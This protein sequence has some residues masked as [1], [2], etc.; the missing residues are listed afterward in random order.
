MSLKTMDYVIKEN[1]LDNVDKRST[2]L[3]FSKDLAE[4]FT[5]KNKYNE[6][7]LKAHPTKKIVTTI[8]NSHDSSKFITNYPVRF[9]EGCGKYII[10][11]IDDETY[12]VMYS[13]TI[14]IEENIY[15]YA[16]IQE[17]RKE[18][19]KY[20]YSIAKYSMQESINSIRRTGSINQL[21]LE[22]KIISNEIY[23][24]KQDILNE[25]IHKLEE[26][27]KLVRSKVSD[28]NLELN[29]LNK[30]LQNYINS[31]LKRLNRLNI[32][33]IAILWEA[34]KFLIDHAS[35]NSLLNFHRLDR[36][37]H[38]DKNM[39]NGDLVYVHVD[40]DES[41]TNKDYIAM[42]HKNT[43][44]SDEIEI[45]NDNNDIIKV[46]ISSISP[47]EGIHYQLKK[48]ELDIDLY[49]IPQNLYYN[50]LSKIGI[51]KEQ[52]DTSLIEI[53]NN[54][55]DN[56]KTLQ[57]N[58]INYG[59]VEKPIKKSKINIKRALELKSKSIQAPNTF[60]E[61]TNLYTTG[62]NNDIFM[63]YSKSS[64]KPLPGAGTQESIKSDINYDS[65]GIID[66]WR[67]KLSNFWTTTNAIKIAD[68]EFASVEHFFHFMKFWEINTLS[69]AKR[70]QYNS[71]ALNFTINCEDPLCWGRSNAN[72]AK[73]KGGIKSGLNHRDEWFQPIE[74]IF[75]NQDHD[76]YGNILLRD[77]ILAVGMYHKFMQNMDLKEM[78]LSTKE[79][80]LI[81]P[82]GGSPRSGIYLK[83]Y[84]LMFVR[85]LIK[86]K[87]KIN[88]SFLDETLKLSLK[89]PKIPSKPPSD[90]PSDSPSKPPPPSKP[91]SGSP[92]KLPPKSPKSPK[93]LKSP[94]K[95]KS[96]LSLLKDKA[97]EAGI[98]TSTLSPRSIEAAVHKVIQKESKAD[99]QKLALEIEN[100]Q[101]VLDDKAKTIY[102][103]P[104]NGDC[105]YHSLVEMMH[106][107][108]IFPLNFAGEQCVDD[109]L[110]QYSPDTITLD[111]SITKEVKHAEILDK[112]M[113][114]MRKEIADKF[115]E[116]FNT[117]GEGDSDSITLAK[118]GVYTSY[119]EDGPYGNSE[120]NEG[121]KADYYNKIKNR[122]LAKGAW[123]SELEFQL[124]SALFNID[125]IIYNSNG[126]TNN[127]RASDMKPI[128]SKGKKYNDD[129][130]TQIIELG[131]YSNFHYIG[132]QPR[133]ELLQQPGFNKLTYYI[134]DINY[135]EGIHKLIL[136]F[137][138]DDDVVPL[139]LYN[140]GK[141]DYFTYENPDDDA[142]VDIYDDLYDTIEE[143]DKRL[144][145]VDYYQNIEDNLVYSKPSITEAP[146]GKLT[147]KNHEDGNVTNKIIFK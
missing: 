143:G 142:I 95:P 36:L 19:S 106:I 75:L 33:N 20:N 17:I 123:I 64:S 81:H 70:K 45:K 125:I 107:D 11:I 73:Q 60:T 65:L 5:L 90:S 44:G 50:N 35:E 3:K 120:F 31:H 109:L 140:Q 47:I 15:I 133:S 112:A 12:K 111:V 42:L 103:V 71:Y 122:H 40:Q 7:L 85:Y 76:G 66:N 28:L 145:K 2:I 63:F 57:K 23:E 102:E 55:D 88:M 130:D 22:N 89:V 59:L 74:N 8:N 134:I 9:K 14:N 82:D 77:Y 21:L 146:M 105:G 51:A 104:P 135:N 86:N 84:P 61:E 27:Y 114:Q 6:F 39:Y 34:Y 147:I 92:P 118:E 79:A 53:I 41:K 18:L 141:I 58:K 46:N 98:D 117:T 13:K 1:Y 96:V 110:C 29:M 52:K 67:R 119:P 144:T 48:S 127:I 129:K 4:Y 10:E 100:L 56:S 93:S 49:I 68:K 139:G 91:P 137:S 24:S 136:D 80:L 43:H 32:D 132:I 72:I 78:L 62:D 99:A 131:Y 138:D 69:G 97:S 30:Y 113:I 38:Q 115:H 83:E 87:K 37:L 16:R 124:A 121:I 94:S 26:E 101:R 108:N 54:T 25:T 116:N 126:S 128:F